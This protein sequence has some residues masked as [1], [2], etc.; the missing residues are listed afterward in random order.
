MFGSESKEAIEYGRSMLFGWET[1][2]MLEGSNR[3]DDN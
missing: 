3:R 2:A 1:D